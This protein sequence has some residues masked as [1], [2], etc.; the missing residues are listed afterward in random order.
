MLL[1]KHRADENLSRKAESSLLG[2]SC[3]QNKFIVWISFSYM[4]LLCELLLSVSLK[5]DLIIYFIG[6]FYLI[7]YVNS[8]S[9]ATDQVS[10]QWTMWYYWRISSWP[11]CRQLSHQAWRYFTFQFIHG[12][13][14]DILLHLTH[15]N[16]LLHD[17]DGIEH[18]SSNS[19]ALLIYG[20][21]FEV[22]CHCY[23]QKL[24]SSNLQSFCHR[25][26]TFLIILQFSLIVGALGF[27]MIFPYRGLVGASSGIYGIIGADTSMLLLNYL[28]MCSQPNELEANNSRHETDSQLQQDLLQP[29]QRGVFRVMHFVNFTLPFILVTQLC[30]DI[31]IYCSDFYEENVGY[32]AHFFGFLAGLF[33]GGIYF[34][35]LHCQYN[36]NSCWRFVTTSIMLISSLAFVSILVILLYNHI[37]HF[38]PSTIRSSYFRSSDEFNCCEEFLHDRQYYDGQRV[39]KRD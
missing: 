24:T 32:L 13:Y 30:A 23:L 22:G 10:P 14:F 36:R 38:P 12:E 28:R 1:S 6:V 7:G 15:L 2:P 4:I 19:A 16:P 35:L 26:V 25:L 8:K 31:F 21:Y 5:W 39:C 29:R 20:T 17:K 37:A 11:E 27:T 3:L 18:I 9:K 33:L 34:S